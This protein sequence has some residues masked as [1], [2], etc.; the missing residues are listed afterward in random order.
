MRICDLQTGQILITRA[1]KR[2][3]EQWAVAQDHWRD[4]NTLKFQQ[5]HLQPIGPQVTL[6]LSAVRRMA[7][8]LEQAERDCAD[9]D[10]FAD[11]P[12]PVEPHE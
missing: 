5:Q 4:A 7:E 8:L 10:E 3:R 11:G 1:A 6:L 9:H 12:H 2:L